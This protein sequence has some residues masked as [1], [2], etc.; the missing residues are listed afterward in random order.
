ML[1]DAPS[2]ENHLLYKELDYLK[3]YSIEDSVF[4]T[5]TYVTLTETKRIMKTNALP[6]H[7][8]GKFPN[9]GNPNKIS[10][11]QMTYE[12]PLKPKR[13]DKPRWAREPGIALNGVKFEPETAERFVCET[14]EV[15]K[16]EAFQDLVNLGLDFNNAHVQP[17][18]AY[19]YHGVPSELIK[20]LDKGEDLILVGFAK[21]GF[22]MY[23]SKSGK[24]KP[25][26]QLSEKNRTG[27]VCSYRNPKNRIDKNL[28]NTQPDGTFVSDWEYVKGKGDLDEC[29]GIEINGEYVY[30]ITKE[31]PFVGRCLM[32]EFKEERP[33]GPPPGMRPHGHPH[34]PPPQH[35]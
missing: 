9:A 5:K 4:G 11:Q 21:D 31:Y 7:K 26:Y 34:G 22:P 14:G 2:H 27:D 19:H 15:Y 30:L 29:N 6:N 13:M 8:T 32:G 17:T 18:G 25:S 1:E 24:Y 33:K 23:Y 10:A 28:N 12:F 16:I 3:S 20:V 35:R